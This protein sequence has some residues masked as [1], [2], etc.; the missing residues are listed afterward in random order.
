MRHV[1]GPTR[2]G[3]LEAVPDGL[4][5]GDA[6]TSRV[7]LTAD[8]LRLPEGGVLAWDDILDLEVEAPTTRWRWPAAVAG[9]LA[10]A[11]QA[12]LHA[13]WVPGTT[14]LVVHVTTVEGAQ[15]S[16]S[17]AGHL[18]WRYHRASA[19]RADALVRDVVASP[20]ARAGLREPDRLLAARAA[21]GV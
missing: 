19:G 4:A 21:R 10:V 17:T 13:D 14:P 5:V 11:V 7:V 8:G 1:N 16:V 2:L 20:E 12:V 6:G 15:S 18:G 3:Y 9:A